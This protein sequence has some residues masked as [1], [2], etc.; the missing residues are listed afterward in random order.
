LIVYI[1]AFALSL[2]GVRIADLW[3]EDQRR[4]IAGSLLA[5]LPPILIAGLRDSTV[6]S[7]MELYIVPIFNGIASNGQNLS[8]FIDSYPEIEIGYLFVNYVIAQLTDQPFFL[9]LSIHILI[10]VPLYITAMRWREQ[11]SPVLFMFIFYMIFY[12]ESLSI[13]RQSIALS[14]SMLAFTFF[15]EKKFIRYFLY[16]AIAFLFHQTAVIA[17]S[18][19]LVYLMVDK[20]SIQKYYYAYIGIILAFGL[21]FL[22]LDNIL[23]WMIENDYI[24]LKFLKYTSA[25]DTFTPV[26]GTANFV[27]KIV[28]IAYIIYVMVLYKSDTILK[29]FLIM[30]ILDMLFSLCALIV[31]PL[32][33]ISLYFALFHA[34]H[35]H[36]LFLITLFFLQKKTLHTHGLLKECSASCFSPI[37][38]MSICWATTMIRPIIRYRQPFLFDLLLCI[39]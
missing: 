1:I 23:I 35:C 36:I 4:F 30:A 24:D 31:Q 8:E 28:I 25:G 29:F 9:L 17:L 39:K 22:N 26:L 27:V 2:L 32:D 19:P 5:V 11:L 21:L 34:S 6:G 13:V 3:Y 14:F 18:F 33:R 10:I 20:F 38:F 16:M 37:G 7:D 15:W 12:Q